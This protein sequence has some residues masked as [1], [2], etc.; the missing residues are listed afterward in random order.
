MDE[1]GGAEVHN[2]YARPDGLLDFG[3]NSN[4]FLE[5]RTDGYVNVVAATNGLAAATYQQLADWGRARHDPDADN[6]PNGPRNCGSPSTTN[7]GTSPPA[8]STTSI[9]T[10]ATSR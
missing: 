10:A 7:C 6:S 3:S 4:N 1:A 8:G 9:P 2:Q 5:I